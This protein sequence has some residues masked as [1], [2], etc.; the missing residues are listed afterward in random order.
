VSA[1]E[2]EI[3]AFNAI[4]TRLEAEHIGEWIVMR[5][6]KVVGFFQT[7]EAAGAEALRLF[8]RGEYLIREVGAEPLRLPVSV[9]Y[10]RYAG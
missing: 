1:I 9:M 7:F 10:H 3:E 6:R 2:D 8:G 5:D 4:R